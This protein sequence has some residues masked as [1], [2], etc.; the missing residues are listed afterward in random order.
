MDVV[1]TGGAGFLGRRI[2][3]AVKD[4]GHSPHPMAMKGEDTQGLDNVF[5]GDITDSNSFEIPKCDIVIHCAGI[6]ESSHPS[7]ELMM[8]VNFEGTK[9]VFEKSLKSGA[10]KFIFISTVSAIGPHGS[11]FRPLSEDMTPDPNDIY[12]LS[13]LEAERFLEEISKNVDIKITVLRPTVLYGPGMNLNSS[14]MKIFTSVKKGIMPLVGKGENTLNM[15]YADNLVHAIIL[16]FKSS[17]RYRI[18]HVSEKS[19]T[20]K[21]IITAIE[22]RMGKK[23]HRQYPKSLLWILTFFSELISPLLKGPPPMSW[24]KYHG[25]TSDI[26]TMSSDRIR[27]ELGFKEPFSLEKGVDI[28]CKHYDW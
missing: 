25:L 14:G 20:Q 23:G 16:S 2:Y 15:L 12:G 18:F 1:I 6:L 26:W 10:R 9:I 13:K 17:R 7:K 8:K 11:K 19:Y 21:E 3:N 5:M 22:K 28:T 27:T 4:S 24:T